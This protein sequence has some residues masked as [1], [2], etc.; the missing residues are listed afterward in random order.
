MGNV[1][2]LVESE[3]TETEG[4]E[5]DEVGEVWEEVGH[6]VVLLTGR[7]RWV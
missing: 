4:V 7:R 6:G 1:E 3:S 2:S 5:G